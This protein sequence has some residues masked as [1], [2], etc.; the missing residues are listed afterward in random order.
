[1]PCFKLSL[2]QPLLPVVS[3]GF[4]APVTWLAPA[5]TPSPAPGISATLAK[6]ARSRSCRSWVCSALPTWRYVSESEAIPKWKGRSSSGYGSHC[7]IFVLNSRIVPETGSIRERVRWQRLIACSPSASVHAGFP[8]FSS[9]N[10][11]L[12]GKY[13]HQDRWFFFFSFFFEKW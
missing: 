5:L 9:I 8:S 10:C 6:G 1:M 7:K 4:G 12:G 2:Q 3:V 11:F 13:D